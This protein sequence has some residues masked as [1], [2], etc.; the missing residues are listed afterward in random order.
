MEP[1]RRALA[2]SALALTLILAGGCGPVTY[3]KEVTRTASADVDA[4]RAAHAETLA[5]YW[6]TLAVEYLRKARE[7]AGRS[8]FE[9]ANR[10]GRKASRAARR[11]VEL[12][13]S[14]GRPRARDERPAPE[15]S[16]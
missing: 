7:E 1:L 8:E 16:P 4:A 5:P 15:G 3:I 6:Y 12:A 9:A 11:A 2:I 13:L 10:F 14:S